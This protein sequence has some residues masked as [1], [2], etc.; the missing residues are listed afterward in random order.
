M[1][2]EPNIYRDIPTEELVDRFISNERQTVDWPKLTPSEDE[3]IRSYSKE[4]DMYPYLVEEGNLEPSVAEAC[5]VKLFGDANHQYSH[6]S[7]QIQYI[8]LFTQAKVWLGYS[9]RILKVEEDLTPEFLKAQENAARLFLE[10]DIEAGIR[11][12]LMARFTYQCLFNSGNRDLAFHLASS[13]F[14]ELYYTKTNEEASKMAK[15]LG[16]TDEINIEHGMA[17]VPKENSE[18][19]KLN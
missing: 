14:D 3:Q 15:T 5:V 4:A 11:T 1:E 16:E 2:F 10:A 7:D 17:F 13:V 12:Y 9:R 8:K 18:K 6:L 19:S